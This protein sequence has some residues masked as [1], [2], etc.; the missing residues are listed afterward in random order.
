MR[1]GTLQ[2]TGTAANLGEPP[3]PQLVLAL[4]AVLP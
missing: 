1:E 2:L 4:V 3:L